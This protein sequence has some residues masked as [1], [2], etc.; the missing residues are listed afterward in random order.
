MPGPANISFGNVANSFVVQVPVVAG[1][2][3]G[4]NATVER[5]YTVIGIR[6]GDVI[7]AN[8]PTAFTSGLGLANARASATDT[9]A[10]SYINSTAGGLSIQAENWLIQVDRPAYDSTAQIPL[11]IG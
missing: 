5:T 7:T 10:L 2:A 1:A 6:V 9:I 3:I 4:A 8:K 11:A